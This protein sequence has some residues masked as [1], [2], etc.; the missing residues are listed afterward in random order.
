M[1]R[2]SEWGI[3]LLLGVASATGCMPQ[4]SPKV[5]NYTIA[6]DSKEKA[7]AEHDE[8]VRRS[9]LEQALKQF[10]NAR[11]YGIKPLDSLLQEADIYSVLG[12][13]IKALELADKVIEKDP[14]AIAYF[15]KGRIENRHGYFAYAVGSLTKSLELEERPETR[16]ERSNSYLRLAVL[17]NRIIPEKVEKA[18]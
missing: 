4:K 5:D 10:Q 16:W 9:G 12:D 14:A 18:I 11:E 3:A 8:E 6:L 17:G 13:P 1:N 15:V 2:V 7:L